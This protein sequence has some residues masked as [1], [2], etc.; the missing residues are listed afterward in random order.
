MK[1]M[2]K[3]FTQRLKSHIVNKSKIGITLNTHLEILKLVCIFLV[4]LRFI[5]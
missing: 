5:N 4:F 3:L 1:F 2:I